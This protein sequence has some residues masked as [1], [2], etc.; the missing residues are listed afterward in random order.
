MAE[1]NYTVYMHINKMDNKKYIGITRQHVEARWQNG[2]GYKGCTHFYRAIKK[3]GWD[4][5]EH[6][7]LYKNIDYDMACY[8]EM[9]LIK[10]YNSN[11][12]KYGYNIEGGGSVNKEVSKESIDKM[13]KNL[14]GKYRGTNSKLFGTKLSEE[15]KA[16]MS[17]AHRGKY[18]KENNNMFGKHHSKETRKIISKKLKG[19]YTGDNSWFSIKVICITTGMIFN[20]LTDAS[21]YYNTYQSGISECCKNKRTSSG[22]LS[23]GT[24]LQ[25]EYYQENKV[26]NKKEY[27][28][29]HC[30]PV[31]CKSTGEIFS[32]IKD[33]SQ[34]YNIKHSGIIACCN[35][36]QKSAGKSNDGIKLV[37]QYI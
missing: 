37:W 1:Y 9:V 3:Y 30:K 21:N 36:K 27:I 8:L 6:K 15:T 5:F 25:W 13:K 17:K 22:T 18:S 29:H 26:Y 11:N 10:K 24:K 28:N 32:S 19:K 14:T 34:Y 12:S 2:Y 35:G 31:L 33:A 7:I 23:D 16:K 4:N 20:S